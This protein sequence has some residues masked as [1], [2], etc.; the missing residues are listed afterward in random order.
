MYKLKDLCVSFIS[1]VTSDKKPAVEKA[2]TKFAIFKTVESIEEKEVITKAQIERLELLSQ[3][4]KKD[5]EKT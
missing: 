2:E 4:I 5:I 1:L 3:K